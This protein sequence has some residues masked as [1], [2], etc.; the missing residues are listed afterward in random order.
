MKLSRLFIALF[1]GFF[2]PLTVV[3]TAQAH[4]DLV[5][6]SPAAD[7]VTEVPPAF[8][9]VTFSEPPITEGAAIVLSDVAG[10][11]I[12]VGEVTFDGAKMS[13][14]SP[15]DLPP[16]EYK[17]TWRVSAQDGHVLTGE[18]NF[19]YNGDAVVS[20]TSPMASPLAV[21]STVVEPVQDVAAESAETESSNIWTYVLAAVFIA[22]IVGT[23]IVAKKRN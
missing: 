2:A 3:S 5:S 14:A 22:A 17:V 4:T 8:I 19:T 20:N 9:S 1:L 16:S 13:V 7:S 10:N 12:P 18:F 15:P 23:L 21:D 11:E 6:T